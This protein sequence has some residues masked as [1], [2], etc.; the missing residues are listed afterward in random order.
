MSNPLTGDFD[1]VAQF[2]LSFFWSNWTEG[3]LLFSRRKI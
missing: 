2:S 1:L 3:Q